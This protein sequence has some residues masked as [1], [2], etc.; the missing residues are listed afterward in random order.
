VTNKLT[1]IQPKHFRWDFAD[2]VAT[3]TLDRPERKNPLTL[4]SYRELTDTFLLLQ[5]VSDPPRCVSLKSPNQVG[6]YH[7]NTRVEHARGALR[8]FD[9][10]A[11]TKSD[12]AAKVHDCIGRLLADLIMQ[13][14][15]EMTKS[16]TK[17]ERQ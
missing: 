9:L 2:R 12:T 1:S 7:T 4:E 11:M 14:V 13:S 6:N 8:T 5:H 10:L 16:T 3:I 15:A 17:S